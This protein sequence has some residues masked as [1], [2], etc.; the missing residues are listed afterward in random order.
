MFFRT[1]YRTNSILHGV[2]HVQMCT[3]PEESQMHSF[4]A[5]VDPKSAV[6]TILTRKRIP[7]VGTIFSLQWKQAIIYYVIICFTVG[8]KVHSKFLCFK[9]GISLDL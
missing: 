6:H 5:L 7:C 8:T 3:S 2:Y 1:I 4:L 9:P